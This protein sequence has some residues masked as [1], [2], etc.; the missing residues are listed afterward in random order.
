MYMLFLIGV[1]QD[2][3]AKRSPYLVPYSLLDERTRRL[4]RGTVTEALS[5]LLVYGYILEPLNQEPG[6]FGT[7][8]LIQFQLILPSSVVILSL[9]RQ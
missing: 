4:G 2:V 5:T 8:I 1:F 7:I 6:M 9:M 3:K